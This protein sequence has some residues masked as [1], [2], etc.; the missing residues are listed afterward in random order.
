MGV[1]LVDAAGFVVEDRADPDDEEHSD[2]DPPGGVDVDGG[3]VVPG[4][5]ERLSCLASRLSSS[6]VPITN[7]TKMDSPVVV[8]L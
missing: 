1:A 2:D 5:P 8:M 4:L 6:M 3:D 7:A